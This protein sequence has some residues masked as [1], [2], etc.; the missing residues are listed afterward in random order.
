MDG[1]YILGQYLL[2]KNQLLLKLKLELSCTIVV[3]P[4]K[5]QRQQCHSK[6]L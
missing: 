4:L 3:L 1:F 6:R 5:L 2:M